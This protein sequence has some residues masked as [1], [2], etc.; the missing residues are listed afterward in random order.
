MPV[1]E[2]TDDLVFPH[3]KLAEP[4]GLLAVQIFML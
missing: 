3:P 4:D 2:L 1:Y